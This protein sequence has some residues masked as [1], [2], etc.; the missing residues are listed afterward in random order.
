M[1]HVTINVH[2]P[3]Q[4]AEILVNDRYLEQRGGMGLDIATIKVQRNEDG[5]EA[6]FN[7][8]IYYKNGRPQVQ[9]LGIKATTETKK[10][11]QATFV[12]YGD[13]P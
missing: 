1:N 2:G 6:R 5:T 8:R 12:D 4:E 7:V 10:S 11:V 3:A 9:I 13:K